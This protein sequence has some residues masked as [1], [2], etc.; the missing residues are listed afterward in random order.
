MLDDAFR[1]SI[2]DGARR[3]RGE[4]PRRIDP[5]AQAL[6]RGDGIEAHRP[7]PLLQ[8]AG[9]AK[10]RGLGVLDAA[11]LP[12]LHAGSLAHE[13]LVDALVAGAATLAEWLAL[14]LPREAPESLGRA[15]LELR[16]LPLVL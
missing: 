6:A 7:L 4:E 1:R 15:R 14:E 2:G 3:R 12:G 5:V 11:A 16:H 9:D 10:A 13:E 8:V